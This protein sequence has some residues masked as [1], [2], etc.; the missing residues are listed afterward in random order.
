MTGEARRLAATPRDGETRG[1]ALE[2]LSAAATRAL[3]ESRDAIAALITPADE[4]LRVAL[5]RAAEEVAGRARASVT[6]RGAPEV[7]VSPRARD[8]LVRIVR[9]AITNATRHGGATAVEITLSA[10]DSLVLSIH[11]NGRGLQRSARPGGFGLMS[12]RQRAQQLD[13]DFSIGSSPGGGT[14]VEVRL[15]GRVVTS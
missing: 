11:D 10:A 12:I 3:D 9:E 1:D 5:A 2:K 4:P 14:V 8:A 6:V 15:P 7:H 13:G